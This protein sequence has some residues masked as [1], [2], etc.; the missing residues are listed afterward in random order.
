MYSFLYFLNVV[1][2]KPIYLGAC[3]LDDSKV[4]M[5]NFH[6]NTIIKEAGRENVNLCFTDTDSLLYEFK[7]FDIFEF[8]KNNKELNRKWL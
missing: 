5:S 7:N 8:M 3:I 6:Y 4:L 1:L 2:N